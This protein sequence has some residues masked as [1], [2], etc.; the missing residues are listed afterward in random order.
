[1]DLSVEREG[2]TLLLRYEDQPN[3]IAIELRF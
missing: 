2:E 1:V 3:G